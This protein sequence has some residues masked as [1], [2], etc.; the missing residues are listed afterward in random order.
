MAL[1]LRITENHGALSRFRTRTGLRPSSPPVTSAY[2]LQRKI[3]RV[4]R[5]Q[6][7]DNFTNWFRRERDF[8]RSLPSTPDQLRDVLTSAVRRI[9]STEHLILILEFIDYEGFSSLVS[10][11]YAQRFSLRKLRAAKK[12]R[13]SSCASE[14]SDVASP[15]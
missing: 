8:R 3:E 10:N 11:F 5:E 2:L 6:V 9:N 14:D 12:N 7:D 13:E 15:P 4:I 1:D